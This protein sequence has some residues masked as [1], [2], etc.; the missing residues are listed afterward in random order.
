MDQVP[1][2]RTERDFPEPRLMKHLILCCILLLSTGLSAQEA[3]PTPT[4]AETPASAEKPE[5]PAHNEL[6]LMKNHMEDAMNARDID[7]ILEGVADEVVFSTMNGDVI[8]GKSEIKKYFE[9][10]MTGPEAKVKE[11][12]TKFTVDKLTILY[13]G[14]DNPDDASFGIAY[15]HSDDEY[16][17]A[18]GTQFQVQPRWSAAMV[19]DGVSWKIA[20]FHYS[21]NM[22]DNPVV[23]KVKS[24]LVLVGAGALLLGLVLGF[25]L[26]R[27]KS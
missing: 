18:D 3:S 1:P 14:N 15:G 11:V 20:N 19:R 12:K 24:T 4:P 2:P 23:S 10:M 27:R 26:G 5:N 16:T 21:V 9:Q 25:L 8:R 7:S 17:L 6:R 22:F 13:S